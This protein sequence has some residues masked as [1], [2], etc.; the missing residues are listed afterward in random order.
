MDIKQGVR[1]RACVCARALSVCVDACGC[2]FVRVWA[3]VF[4]FVFVC[5]CVHVCV[6]ATTYLCIHM[7][8]PVCI[9]YTCVRIHIHTRSG[10]G[11]KVLVWYAQHK[12]HFSRSNPQQHFLQLSSSPFPQAGKSRNEKMATLPVTVVIFDLVDEEASKRSQV[13]SMCIRIHVFG[14]PVLELVWYAQQK[15]RVPCVLSLS[16]SC[17]GM[18]TSA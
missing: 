2:V 1:L 15:V 8:V 17:S 12:G 4:V 7:Y 16:R 6:G 3:R 10:R 13:Y 14:G 9:D 11:V 18:R 5:V